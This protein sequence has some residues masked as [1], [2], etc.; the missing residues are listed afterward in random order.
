M[1]LPGQ[2]FVRFEVRF[3]H[4][5]VQM[6]VAQGT[7]AVDED[8]APEAG[9]RPGARPAFAQ[10]SLQQTFI[11][12]WG[13]LLRCFTGSG[14]NQGVVLGVSAEVQTR[15]SLA[16]SGFHPLFGRYTAYPLTPGAAEFD[17]VTSASPAAPARHLN[18]TTP[19]VAAAAR[20]WYQAT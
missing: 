4:V 16:G 9:L 5:K 3:C 17:G 7:E 6:G 11:L 1:A 2:G 18:A 19:F 15:N 20:L 10:T 13:Y 14:Y 12:V 8:D